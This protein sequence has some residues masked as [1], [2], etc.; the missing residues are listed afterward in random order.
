M[1]SILNESPLLTRGLV[2]RTP[3]KVRLRGVNGILIIDKPAGITSHDVVYNVRRALK[4]KRVGHTGTLDPFATGVMVI[5]V[6]QSTRLAQFLDKDV[7]EYE[8]VVRFGFETDTGDRTGSPKSEAQGPP[9]VNIDD[10]ERVLENFRGEIEQVPPMYSAKKIDGKKLY[11]LARKGE[12]VERKA[13]KVRIEKLELLSEPPASA[14]GTMADFDKATIKVACSAGTYIRT[15]AEDIGRKL[16]TGA[17]LTELR[18]TAAGRFTIVEA[19]TLDEL[20]G[21]EE[22]ASRLIPMEEAVAHLAK[23]ELNEDRAKKTKNGLSTR[24][25]DVEFI[26]GEVVQMLDEEKKLIAIGHFDAAENVV[27]PKVV[28]V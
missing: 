1:H 4:T 8:A 7:K 28:L 20:A 11:E 5:L 13:V 10:V 23:I 22:P 21:M 6:G 14:G 3:A 19:M 15:L 9:W 27:Q 18:R 17:H 12:T 24:V 25:F 16:G 2:Q 26:D